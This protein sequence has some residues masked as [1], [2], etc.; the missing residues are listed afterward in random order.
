M[1]VAEKVNRLLLVNPNGNARVTAQARLSAE[2]VIGTDWVIDAVNPTG[3]PFSIQG[4]ADRAAAEPLAIEILEQNPGY[5]AYVMACFDDIAVAAG[6]KLYKAPVVDPVA[7]SIAIAR[8]CASRFSIVTTV[9]EMA[10]GIRSLVSAMG[11]SGQCSVRAAGISVADAAAP[12]VDVADRLDRAV[13]LAHEQ[14][15]AG[16]IILGSGGLAGQAGPLAR[17]HGLPVIDCIE[18]AVLLA[19]ATARCVPMGATFQSGV[20]AVLMRRPDPGLMI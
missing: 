16:A 12:D 17:R 1:D 11:A 10:P 19:V 6:R 7:A 5:D 8:L 3:G 13:A 14:D 20:Q 2:R 15:G 9:E 4:P 18:A